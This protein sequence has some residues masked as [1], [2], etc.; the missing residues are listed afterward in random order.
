MT[1]NSIIGHYLLLV[2][3]M[4]ALQ[5]HATSK[6]INKISYVMCQYFYV[7]INY[8]FSLLAIFFFFFTTASVS[9]KNAI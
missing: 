4:S 7:L 5:R 1:N 2:L 3:P 6:Q 8:R 9:K